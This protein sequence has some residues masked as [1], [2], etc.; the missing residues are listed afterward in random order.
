MQALTAF[1]L[2]LPDASGTLYIPFGD[3]EVNVTVNVTHGYKYIYAE[4][5]KCSAHT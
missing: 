4:Q 1:K 2:Y 5:E 3:K